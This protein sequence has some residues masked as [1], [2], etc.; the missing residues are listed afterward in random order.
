MQRCCGNLSYVLC[1]SWSCQDPNKQHRCL[2]EKSCWLQGK[3]SRPT[4]GRAGCEHDEECTVRILICRSRHVLISILPC[5]TRCCDSDPGPFLGPRST[6]LQQVEQSGPGMRSEAECRSGTRCAW[7]RQRSCVAVWLWLEMDR[8]ERA[9]VPRLEKG[10]RRLFVSRCNTCML[11]A[12]PDQ[13]GCDLRG[14]EQAFGR[15]VAWQTHRGERLESGPWISKADS[16]EL[17]SAFRLLACL[18]PIP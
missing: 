4:G 1:L 3:G 6:A 16:E 14:G 13:M 8:F 11:Q 18:L 10:N 17:N 12:G 15:S 7:L 5:E 9:S 2:P